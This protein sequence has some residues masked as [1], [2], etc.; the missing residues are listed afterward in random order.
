MSLNLAIRL[1]QYHAWLEDQKDSNSGLMA[2]DKAMDA[3]ATTVQL[4]LQQQQQQQQQKQTVQNTIPT[5]CVRPEVLQPAVAQPICTQA[6]NEEPSKEGGRRNR[7]LRFPILKHLSTVTTPQTYANIG[8]ATGKNYGSVYQCL[9]TC[10]ANGQVKKIGENTWEIT[11]LGRQ[12]LTGH[13][14]A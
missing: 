9:K 5:V 3:G 10:F 11:D 13:Y 8:G 2:W 12:E 6:A 14:T 1:A 7:D 4:P